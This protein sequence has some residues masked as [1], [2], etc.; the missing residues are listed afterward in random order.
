MFRALE[1]MQLIQ[2][3]GICFVLCLLD[4]GALITQTRDS[5]L[6]TIP[7]DRKMQ[8]VSPCSSLRSW[9]NYTVTSF[10]ITER[11]QEDRFVGLPAHPSS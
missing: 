10:R 4:Y 5:F 7:D 9:N 1:C 3:S 6:F 2:F 11:V 8:E